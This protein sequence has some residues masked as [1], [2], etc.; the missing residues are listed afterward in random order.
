MIRKVL[1]A[2]R[3]EIACRIF[4]TLKQM[5]IATV[6]VYSEADRSALHVSMAN[7]SILIGPAVAA[8]SYLDIDRI[9]NAAGNSGADAVHP[10]YGFLSENPALVRALNAAGITF[11]GPGAEAIE[12]MGLKDAAKR[13][14]EKAG[15]PVVPGY[16][17]ENQEPVFLA[18]EADKI[19]Y[20]VLIK[21]RAGGGG[22]GMRKV[23]QPEDFAE[24]LAAAQ[25]EGQGSFADP[26]VLVEKYIASPRHIEVQVFGDQHGNVV[27]LFERDCSLQ[28]RHQKV[29]EEA[30]APG[31]TDEMRSAMGRAA[32]QAARAVGYVG[33]GTVEFI[34]DASDGLKVDGFYFMEM[35]TRLQV[36][37]PVTEA[38]T[39]TDL[40]R[41]QI[42]VVNGKPLPLTQDQLVISGHA[43]E[44][45]IYAEDT[46]NGFLPSTGRLDYMAL[47]PSARIDSGVRQ[48]DTIT[49]FY[50]PMIAKLIVHGDN[51][52]AALSKLCSA[53]GQS[54]IVGCTTNIGFLGRLAR[55]ASFRTGNVETGLI[56][57]QQHLL[58]RPATIPHS[59]VV[60]AAL[61]RSAML[62]Q[63]PQA[64]P[65]DTLRGWRPWR[66][67]GLDL[68]LQCNDQRIEINIVVIDLHT[69]RVH[70]CG[71]TF[72]VTDIQSSAN[73]CQFLLDSAAA[74]VEFFSRQDSIYIFDR[75]ETYGIYFDDPLQSSGDLDADGSRIAAPMPGAIIRV[76]VGPGDKV[77]KQ[78]VLMVMEAMK[79]EHSLRADRDGVVETLNVST[80]DQVEA[81]TILMTLET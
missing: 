14:M 50:D 39:G 72:A 8:Q 19:G 75:D 71:E 33:A 37:H 51:R 13:L 56:E 40:V 49:P 23:E 29:I 9:V 67:A 1:V 52:E 65:W 12:A 61:W 16:H 68:S 22:K 38:I 47:D 11:I 63:S 7:E 78:Q 36:E 74:S 30:P 34:V 2:N 42:E 10:G 3:G 48:G 18:A 44:A 41:W 55:L 17:G 66:Q 21:A 25:R 59:A 43:F 28:R 26:A 80:G 4:R 77:E 5:E 57:Q 76:E 32:V 70:L 35:N 6:A 79:M 45:R 69:A 73:G 24:A 27:H 60:A 64:D 15:I 58:R 46:D 53:L 20:P 31:M 81:G 54:R 62:L